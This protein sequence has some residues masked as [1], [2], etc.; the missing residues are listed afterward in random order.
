MER[1]ERLFTSVSEEEKQAVR[2]KA[3]RQGITMSEFVRNAVL[4]KVDVEQE[5]ETGNST[6]ETT[7]TNSDPAPIATQTD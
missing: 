5:R 4:D 2:M 3:A 1:T 7:A 6:M